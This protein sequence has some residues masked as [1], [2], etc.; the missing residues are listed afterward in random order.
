MSNDRKMNA[1]IEKARKRHGDKYDYSKVEYVDSQT[2]VCIVCPEHGEFWQTPA[3]HVRGNSCPKCANHNRGSNKRWDKDEFVYRSLLVHGTKYTYENVKYV[4]N[5]TKV[6]I[7]CPI[8]G[9]FWQTP[10][11]HVFNE[12]GCPKCAGRKRNLQDLI[13][14]FRVVHG[15]KYDYS[16]VDFKKAHDKVCVVCPEHGEFWQTPAKHLNGQGCPKCGKREGGLKGRLSK[17]DFISRAIEMYGDKYDYSKVDYKTSHDK[18][19]IVCKR[20]G[21]FFQRPY[22]HLNGHG[23][24]KCAI[25]VSKPEEE[26][27]NFVCDIVGKGRVIRGDRKV[28]G[29]GREL[30]IYIPTMKLAFEYDGLRWHNEQYGKDRYYHLTKSELCA[31]KGVHLIHIFEDEY[32]KTKDILFCKLSYILGNSWVF[33]RIPA[34]KCTVMEISSKE[35]KPFLDKNH[36]QGYTN[37]S[38]IFGGFYNNQLVGVMSFVKT[39]NENEWVLNRYS[40]DIHSICQGLGSKLFK[41]FVDKYNPSLVKSFLDR[42][43]CFSENKNLYTE[44]GFVLSD[45]LAPD[46]RYVDKDNP[47]ERIHK[48]NLRKKELHRRYN[49]D[50]SMTERQMVE[51][52]GYVK[53]WDCGLYKYV[54]TKNSDD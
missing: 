47:T 46:Y 54:W 3:A 52:L 14:E 39:G 7:T 19:E 17:D 35:A 33:Q 15:N 38:V 26:I 53:I 8:H 29:D 20:H 49:L 24:P 37:S 42:R 32:T 6:E 51:K 18:V 43:W 28:L 36:I 45:T 10:A 9:S 22:D 16:K 31:A 44:I 48:F 4:N 23:C 5:Y 41:H 11:A 2:K 21:S 40:T 30:D 12:Q 27:Y 13:N 50:M 25:I 1:F 34:R